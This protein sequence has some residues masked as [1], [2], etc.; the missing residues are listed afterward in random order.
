MKKFILIILFAIGV[1]TIKAQNFQGFEH[2]LD[3]A[4]DSMIA[5]KLSSA[6]PKIPPFE[7]LYSISAIRYGGLVI[8]TQAS[9]GEDSS[10]APSYHIYY[11]TKQN[12]CFA[13]KI[14]YSLDEGDRQFK[15]MM[16]EFNMVNDSTL[17]AKNQDLKMVRHDDLK[18]N[19][20]TFLFT[21]RRTIMPV[22]KPPVPAGY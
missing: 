13:I 16:P 22:Y 3:T 15:S 10:S 21:R 9:L 5:T 11:Y 17:H 7:K 18:N 4:P 6:N 20:T 19:R 12:Q 2:I 8:T 1:V 14:V